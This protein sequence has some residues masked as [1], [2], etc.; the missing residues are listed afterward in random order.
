[1]RR[2]GPLVAQR[3]LVGFGDGVG[4]DGS[5]PSAEALAGL[6]QELERVGRGTRRGSAFRVGPMLFDQMRLQGRGDFIGRLERMVDGL[7]PRRVVNHAANVNTLPGARV[8]KT[9]V[10]G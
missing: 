4:L 3:D 5:E 9:W 7:V 10:Q 2:P 8:A 6:A 1:M